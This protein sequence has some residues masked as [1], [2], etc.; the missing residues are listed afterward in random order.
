MQPASGREK[1]ADRHSCPTLRRRNLI[2]SKESG[3]LREAQSSGGGERFQTLREIPRVNFPE[4]MS[5]SGNSAPT[6]T[7]DFSWAPKVPRRYPEDGRV[8][9]STSGTP[10]PRISSTRG[11]AGFSRRLRRS[12]DDSWEKVQM[13]LLIREIGGLIR[14]QNWRLK[15]RRPAEI[16][17]L[18]R[19]LPLIY[20]FRG[21][22]CE[23][24]EP[25]SLSQFIP[26]SRAL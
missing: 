15:Q 20:V 23:R 6:P 4:D 12:A 25:C 24:V 2:S 18:I 14:S 3:R 13:R 22:R 9:D 7:P 26:T 21:G 17:G 16:G 5:P 11:A 19:R 10:R 1:V 8:S